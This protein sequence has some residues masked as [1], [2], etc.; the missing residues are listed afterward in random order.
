M[1]TILHVVDINTTP[2][3]VY[4]AVLTANGLSSWWST[5][6]SLDDPSAGSVIDFTFV[7]GF[8][9]QM[10][11]TE[12]SAPRAVA[13][14]CV[15]GH[16]PWSDNTFRFEIEPLDGERSRLTFTQEYAVELDDVAYGIY[17]FNWG[18]YM[19]SLLEY[20]QTGTGKPFQPEV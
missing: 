9:P 6:V 16:E 18:Y 13:W 4:E 8:N 1:K 3:A 11:I 7:E 15:G 14:K 17:N 10:E 12:A 2:E 20:L 19:Q 5:T